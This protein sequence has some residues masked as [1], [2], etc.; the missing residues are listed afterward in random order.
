MAPGSSEYAIDL[1]GAPLR[2][3]WIDEIDGAP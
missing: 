1:L 3:D 2:A